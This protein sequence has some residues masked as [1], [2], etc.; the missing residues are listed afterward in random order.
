[1]EGSD[2][3]PT[4]DEAFYQG[5]ASLPPSFPATAVG[6]NGVPYLIDTGDDAPEPFRREGV[7]VVQQRN[8][9]DPRDVLLLPQGIWRQQSTDWS[10]GCGQM[11][12]D[13]ETSIQSRFNS[14]YGVDV[15]DPWQI[16]LLP[17]TRQ[18]GSMLSGAVWLQTYGD[19][20]A[21]VNGQSI[22]WWN[23]VSASAPYQTTTPHASN[24]TDVSNTGHTVTTLHADGQIWTSPGPTGEARWYTYSYPSASF[25]GWA[26]DYLLVGNLNTLLNITGPSAQLIYTHPD[27]SF[28]FLDACDGP[29]TIYTVGQVGDHTEIHRIGINST[30]TGLLPGVVAGVLPD[31]E[32]GRSISSYLGFV[33]VGSDKGVRMAQPDT[34]GD[35]TLGAL[36]PSDSPVLCFEGQEQFVW[37]GNG[38]VDGTYENTPV[39]AVNDLFPTTPVPGLSRMDLTTFTTTDLTP[40]YATDLVAADETAS[41]VRS[42]VTWQDIRVFSIDGVGVYVQDTDLMEGG[43]L[44][45]GVMS[46]SV[47]DLK[48]AM[49]QQ[50]QVT[51]D[52]TGSVYIDLSFDNT[53][54]L[55]SAYIPLGPE[56]NTAGG[57][58][59][60]QFTG[61][62]ARYVLV[63]EPGADDHGPTLTRWE[64]RSVPVRGMA[65]RWIIPIIATDQAVI[66]EVTF[67]QDAFAI[68]NTLNG[69]VQSSELVTLQVNGVSIPVVARQARTF[70]KGPSDTGQGWCGT[71]VLTLEQ[72]A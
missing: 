47:S 39:D 61:V 6:I 69:Y 32:T 21:V 68:Q 20:L 51:P 25:I 33:F 55:R 13:R 36:L 72:V 43:W 22:H 50:A 15:W 23:S 42:V 17:R 26:K 52:S 67:S 59:G 57:L 35:L 56:T 41:T 14:S 11:Y 29:A 70:Y 64:I 60:R 27:P 10:S 58:D 71:I 63:R 8:T 16:S 28:R 12:L 40:A 66:E 49:Y 34:S 9:G 46:Y 4:F 24:V 19:Y 65:W 54:W 44:R 48:T 45:E 31:G 5:S 3:S 62:E 2:L 18:L 37:Y 53:G 1:M 7:D 38:S 30:A